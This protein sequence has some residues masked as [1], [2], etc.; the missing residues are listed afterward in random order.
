VERRVERFR[1]AS[2]EERHQALIKAIKSYSTE[3][4]TVTL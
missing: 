2:V 3:G 1:T 4:D